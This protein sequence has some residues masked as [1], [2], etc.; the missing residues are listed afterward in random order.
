[1]KIQAR[2]KIFT[3]II[4]I[5]FFLFQG[6]IAAQTKDVFIPNNSRQVIHG[7]V[8]DENGNPLLAQ[9]Q[10]WYYPLKPIKFSTKNDERKD[11]LISMT[12]TT[13]KGFYN[14]RVPSDTVVLIISKGPEWS[15]I[16]K[17]FIINKR[18]FNGIEFNATLNHIYDLS[19][20]GL[21]AGDPHHH[22]IFSDAYETPTEIA[23]AMRSVGL[24]WGIL[25]DHNSDEGISE[26]LSCKSPDFIPIHGCE[27]TTEPTE[28]SKE[29]GYGHL[30]ESFIKRING[31]KV[32]DPNIWARARFSSHQ[33]VQD[34]INMV[35]AQKGFIAL[36]HPFQSWDWSG[37]FK[38]WGKVKDFDAIE[39]WNG[40]PPHGITMNDWDTNHI[41]INTWGV[42]SWFEYLNA[43]NKLSAIAG[44]DCH[45]IYGV[46]AYPKCDAYWTTTTGNPRTYVYASELSEE[47]IQKAMKGGKAFLTSNFG[48]LLLIDVEGKIPGEVVKVKEDGKI[49]IKLKVMANQPLLK[50]NSGLRIIFNGKII[51]E[52]ETDTVYTISKDI[53]LSPGKDGWIV[54]EAFGQWPMYSI[55]N[56]IYIDYPPYGDNIKSS[57][58]DPKGV[59][60]WNNFLS[61]PQ[62]K[63]PDGTSNWKDTADSI[64]NRDKL[65]QK[66]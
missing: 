12:Y 63:L 61:H 21:Y 41:N 15:I 60:S 52:I 64:K 37:R 6:G 66:N 5:S 50:T 9:V 56:P 44:S 10:L 3:R 58:T 36:N 27:I 30:N 28:I 11:N 22:S 59:E 4:L 23:R 19:S 33:D 26:W 20:I 17:K 38:S 65:V 8:K 16:K 13:D 7:T 55:T 54:V 57:W 35:H 62:L 45:D 2:R 39:V 31:T 51:S 1:M 18:E 25:S 40:E 43:G 34:M 46:N 24:S 47:N 48:P 14:V 42:H 32:N 53:S 29:N 49:N